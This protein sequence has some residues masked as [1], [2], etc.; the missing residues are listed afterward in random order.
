MLLCSVFHLLF[1]RGAF[2]AVYRAKNKF[3]DEEVAIKV[4]NKRDVKV[5]RSQRIVV[6]LL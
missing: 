5:W 1:Y 4:V 6:N 3:T 2:S